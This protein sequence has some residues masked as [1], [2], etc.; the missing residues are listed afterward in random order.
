MLDKFGI[1]Q[2]YILRFILSIITN[3]MYVPFV[4]SLDQI[5]QLVKKVCPEYKVDMNQDDE[6]IVVSDL[7]QKGRPHL[8]I[9]VPMTYS[10]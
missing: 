1:S 3:S 6:K 2:E 10:Q 4:G 8:E 7:N 9:Q 5:F